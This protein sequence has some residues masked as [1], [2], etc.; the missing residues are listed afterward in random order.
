MDDWFEHLVK[1][2]IWKAIQDEVGNIEGRASSAIHDKVATMSPGDKLSSSPLVQVLSTDV[3]SVTLLV[4]GRFKLF[5]GA[6]APFIRIQV[7]VSKTVDTHLSPPLTILYW[8]TVVG[9]LQ[10]TKARLRVASTSLRP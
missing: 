5:G 10:I 7:R 9:D 2:V 4:R 8:D 3:S 1:D 6:V